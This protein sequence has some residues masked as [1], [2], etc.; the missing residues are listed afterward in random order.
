VGLAE[1]AKTSRVAGD[2]TQVAPQRGLGVPQSLEP[3]GCSLLGL[4]K[5]EDILQIL[6]MQGNAKRA[7]KQRCQCYS[8]D[9]HIHGW[10]QLVIKKGQELNVVGL[11]IMFDSITI[12]P[13]LFHRRRG[14][15][16][17]YYCCYCY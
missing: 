2:G 7:R 3:G 4:R 5:T 14:C 13:G 12:N 6:R 16:S 17:R 1:E 11:L 9:M 10:F 15:C 8:F